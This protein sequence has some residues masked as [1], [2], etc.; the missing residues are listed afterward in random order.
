MI[1][2]ESAYEERVTNHVMPCISQ[3]SLAN[4]DDSSWKSLNYQ[5]LLK[6]R[7]N[8]A[9]V[10]FTNCSLLTILWRYE[11]QFDKE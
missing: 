11:I 3:L 1:G 9:K 4:R 7:H 2:G 6:T 5:V 8:S 10:S